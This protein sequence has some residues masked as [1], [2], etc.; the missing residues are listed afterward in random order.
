MREK[1]PECPKCRRSMQ[2]GYLLDGRHGEQRAVS[3]WVEGMPEKSFWSGLKIGERR[4]M[5]VTVYRC[6]RC[7]YLESYAHPAPPS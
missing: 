7:G 4:V 1:I 5:P 2:R 3:E 6:D